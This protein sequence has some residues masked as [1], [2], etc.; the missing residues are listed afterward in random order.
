MKITS[1]GFNSSFLLLASL[2]SFSL[3][4]LLLFFYFLFFFF[5]GPLSVFSFRLNLNLT[6]FCFC[7][8]GLF[9]LSVFL[10]FWSVTGEGVF[11]ENSVTCSSIQRSQ[12]QTPVQLGLR[13]P[14]QIVKLKSHFPLH[15]CHTWRF[16][17]T[18]KTRFW[19]SFEVAALS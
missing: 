12:T 9:I 14:D 7:L 16:V 4:C 5:F 17:W 18:N 10:S 15:L 11:P 3:C 19:I 6:L 2:S 8:F 1:I 13:N